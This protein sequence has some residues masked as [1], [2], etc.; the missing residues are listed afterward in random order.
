MGALLALPACGGSDGDS[1]PAAPATGSAEEDVSAEDGG[2]VSVSGGT[3]DISPGALADDTTI[4]VESEQPSDDLP[5]FD[6]IA[7]LVYDF[8]PDG[9]VFEEPVEL[10]LPLV[11]SPGDK[12]V[13][14]SW[15]DEEAD[16]WV[17]LDTDVSGSKVTAM[18]EHFTWFV[19]RFTGGGSTGDGASCEDFSACGGDPTGSWAL[20]EACISFEGENPFESICE[21]ATF[22]VDFA[23][24]GTVTMN[25]NGTYESSTGGDVTTIISMPEDCL[26]SFQLSSCEELEMVFE[27][28]DCTTGADGCRCETTEPGETETDTG[29]WETSGSTLSL[30]SDDDGETDTNDYC[31]SGNTFQIAFEDEDVSGV[32]AATRR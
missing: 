14:I 20:S 12:D 27:G 13:V 8:G 30:T 15:L 26:E 9:T 7:G 18:V 6:S 22:E 21:G 28:G 31:V 10:T 32:W 1:G 24:D 19:V 3:L 4:T 17:D 25:A 16:R 23:A 29:T 5:D 11:G 2:E